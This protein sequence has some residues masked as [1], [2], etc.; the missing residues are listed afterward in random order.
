M[1]FQQK[2]SR[3]WHPHCKTF[4]CI[5]TPFISDCSAKMECKISENITPLEAMENVT[6]RSMAFSNCVVLPRRSKSLEISPNGLRI[7]MVVKFLLSL[8]LSLSQKLNEQENLEHFTFFAL[9]RWKLFRDE[10][11]PSQLESF[12]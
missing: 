10:V 4:F 5:C 3:I 6:S 8:Q 7:F 9:L 1:S 12:M 2:V 11:K